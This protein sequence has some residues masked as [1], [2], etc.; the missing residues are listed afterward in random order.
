V[1]RSRL[2]ECAAA[3]A[4][5]L[6]ASAW[7]HPPVTG[8]DLWWHLA[9]GREVAKRGAPLFVDVFSFT[10]AGK[11]WLNPEWLWDAVAWRLYAWDPQLLAWSNLALL[12][13]LFAV[14]G[15]T[16]RATSGSRFAAS[17]A[18]VGAA[19]CSHTFFDIRPHLATLLFTAL[20][21]LVRDAPAAPWLWPL[22]VALWANVHGGFVFGIGAIGLLVTTHTLTR[23]VAA[24]R[25]T[26]RWVAWGALA[27]C[28]VVWLLNPWGG[29]L[30]RFPLDL[31]HAA[32]PYR[33]IREWLPPE[34]TADPRLYGGRFLWLAAAAGGGALLFARRDPFLVLVSAVTF[35][36]ALSAR[37]F[38]P[39]F[40]VTAAPLVAVSVAWLQRRATRRWPRLASPTTA[41]VTTAFGALLA[42][43]LLTQVRLRPRLFERWVSMDFFPLEAVRYLNALGPPVRLLNTNVWGGFLMIHAP[44]SRL[45]I[46]GRGSAVYPDEIFLDHVAIKDGAPDMATR[47]ARY[48]FDAAILGKGSGLAQRLTELPEPWV[49]VYQDVTAVILLPPDS[50]LLRMPLP[51]A[52]DVLGPGWQSSY[53]RIGRALRDGDR[54]AAI[55]ELEAEVAADPLRTSAWG[56][57]AILHGL[58]HDVAAVR[59]SLAAALRTEPRR[60][61]QLRL[62]EAEAYLLAGDKRS[63]I[64]AYRDLLWHDPGNTGGFRARLAELEREVDRTP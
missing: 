22:L 14:V 4:A 13:V 7:F 48:R 45:F 59:T 37:R 18:V 50:L 15:E 56:Y 20:L 30:I 60:R 43:L 10:A 53:D 55:R 26:V 8:E 5:V 27:A 23:S 19:A 49:I 44:E 38:I 42:A 34:L 61:V 57:L 51:T 3:V 31:L 16:C 54:A 12:L 24:G 39:L 11:T 32:S 29:A 28:L 25:L 46:D 64:G 9:S 17:V 6:C 2:V 62:A 58:E 35:A 40:A 1:K 21:L 52:E 33:T 47:L 63:A 36:M 41:I